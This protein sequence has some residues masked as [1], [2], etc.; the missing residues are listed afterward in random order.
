M[1]AMLEHA[2]RPDV[3]AVGAQ[4]LFPNDT[5]QHAGV[6][7]GLV[8]I[9]AHVFRGRDSSVPH[10]FALSHA[11]RNCSAVTA[12]CLLTRRDV[13]DQV[14]RFDERNLPTCFQDVDL[15]LKMVDAGLSIVYTP[16]A[17]LHHYES[18]TK[19]AIARPEEIEYMEQRWSRYIVEDPFYNPNLSRTSD[20]YE[21]H[22][23]AP[24]TAL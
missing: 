22:L 11:V 23:S 5:I 18:A 7:V 1:E 8:G 15:C 9:A 17:R 12:A 14:G 4:L 10:Y 13:F 6:V 21:L 24:T 20:Q 16:Y 19:R 2:Q 3:G